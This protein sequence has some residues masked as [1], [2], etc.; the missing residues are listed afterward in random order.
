MPKD[1]MKIK[2]KGSSDNNEGKSDL[3][4][5]S[6]CWLCFKLHHLE[7]FMMIKIFLKKSFLFSSNKGES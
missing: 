4:A 1:R 5:H 3:K 6:L 7:Y 2:F